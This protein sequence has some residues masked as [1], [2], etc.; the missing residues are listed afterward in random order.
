MMGKTN[1]KQRIGKPQ[2]GR[3][4]KKL[5]AV[6]S[7]YS[8]EWGVRNV[9]KK[10]PIKINS[11]PKNINDQEVPFAAKM[12]LS[13]DSRFKRKRNKNHGPK[14]EFP[15]YEHLKKEKGMTRPVEPVPVFQQQKGE[16]DLKFMQRVESKCQSVLDDVRFQNKYGLETKMAEDETSV[17][18]A[19]SKKQKKL[20]DEKTIEKQEKMNSQKVEKK[21]NTKHDFSQL[22][23][24]VKFGEV[25]NAPPTLTAKPRKSNNIQ[26]KPGLKKSLLLHEVIQSNTTNTLSNN[27]GPKT[28]SR[29]IGKTV[30][31]KNLSETEKIRMDSEQERAIKLYREMK[32]KRQK[33]KNDFNT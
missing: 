18:T 32:A 27:P 6:D 10:E 28:T 21:L 24:K 26:T 5:K 2:K 33:M 19:A 3:K 30:K 9:K 1:M 13:K 20:Q 11:R 17:K 4:H 8:A 31:R 29:E 16:S 14:E 12:I 22:S 23:D 7:S 25:V 15:D